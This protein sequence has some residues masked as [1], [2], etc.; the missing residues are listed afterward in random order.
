MFR[1]YNTYFFMLFALAPFAVFSQSETN[2]C[3]TLSR[4]NLIVQQQHYRPKPVDDSLSV[5]VFKTFID[6]LDE[7]NNLFLQSEIDS[8]SKNRLKIDNYIL[9]KDC[10]F[11]G[12]IFTVYNRA[13]DR[14]SKVISEIKQENFPLESTE[15]VQFSKTAFPYLKDETQ[16]K[17]FY[18][19]SMLFSVLKD[20]AEVSTNVDSV[21]A[22][23]MQIGLASRLKVFDRYQCKTSGYRFSEKD[24]N[25]KFFSV[26]CSYFDPHTEYFS[27]S[28]KSSFLSMVS[29]DNLTFGIYFS[30]NEKDAIAVDGLIPGSS[31]Y[32]T[33]KIDV[34]DELQKIKYQNQEF[35]VYCSALDLIEKIISSN[36]YLSAEFTFRKKSGEIYSVPLV[37]KVMKD[38][39]N[40]VFSYIIQQ[41]NTKTGYIKIPSF[42]DTFE[43]GKT[44]VSRDVAREINKLNNDKIDGLIID[45]EN[46][47]GGSME[48]AIKL[49]DFFLGAGPVAIMD[50]HL[51]KHEVIENYS[52]KKFYSGP[53]VV[54]IN[55]FSASAS[56][57]F[58]NA[59]QDYNRAIVIGNQSQ[60]KASMQQILPLGERNDEYLK[61]TLEK[62]YRVT[63]KSNQ[64]S[65]ITPDI[66]IPALFDK[67]MPRESTYPTALKSDM[68]LNP[69]KFPAFDSQFKLHEIE[70][71]K[72][73]ISE[74][75][76]L[77]QIKKINVRIDA[78]YD[79]A[80]PPIILQYD[81]VFREVNRI[82]TLWKEIQA[83]SETEYP[84][85]VEN[86]T[87]DSNYQK[88]D[89]YLSNSNGEKIKAIKSNL[90]IV[91]AVNI[92]N[93][94]Y[95][96][97]K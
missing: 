19:K 79:A 60:G 83:V 64:T 25:S 24:F 11:L 66:E 61:L 17:A 87:F 42:Y 88:S 85:N 77:A 86:N 36:D 53:M 32:F 72:K 9:A 41:D 80:M 69:V 18:K 3:E 34:G 92:L 12:E 7:N 54:M 62:F 71:S 74:S 22:N 46:N 70:V 93:D 35:N 47:G 6:K 26:F 55:G 56:E 44:A 43:N 48:E 1:N 15:S 76:P 29:A 30:M 20:M 75:L 5:Y 81:N 89:L 57:F 95:K 58:T 91:E 33:Q 16:L 68:V 4:I 49:T 2:A 14:Y 52:R 59:I 63:G 90:H 84:M 67:Q 27:E 37:K 28:D 39:E 23:F 40:N 45:L 21:C 8:L 13:I 96:H 97:P 38:Y 31:A 73:R 51:G 78:A 50:D 10:S 82:N 65:G 94:L